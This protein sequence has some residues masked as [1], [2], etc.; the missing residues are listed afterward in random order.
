MDFSPLLETCSSTE[1]FKFQRIEQ[2]AAFLREADLYPDYTRIVS[3]G[4]EPEV[5]IDGRDVLMFCSNNYLSLSNS[6]EVKDAASEA[7]LA[8]GMGPG[9]S[10]CLCGNVAVLDDLDKT[11]AELVSMPAAITFPTGYMANLA[12]FRGL[13]DPF[14]G[15]FP[16][17]K[18]SA[19]VFCDEYNHATIMDGIALSHAKRVLFAHNDLRQLE[20]KLVKFAEFTP[21]L[22]VTEGVFSLDGEVS[23]LAELVELARKHDAI[24]MVDDAHGIGM[25]GHRGGGTLDHLGLQGKAD[26]VMGSFDKALGGMGGFIGSSESVVDYLRVSA[27]P[28]MFSSAVPEVMAAGMIR[29]IQLCMNDSGRRTRLRENAAYLRSGLQALG[30]TILGDGSVPVVPIHIGDEDAAIAFARRTLELGL[31][32]PPFRWPTVPMKTAR[33]RVSPMAD[34]TREHLDRAIGI[35]EQVGRELD[36]LGHGA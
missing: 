17:R 1:D 23:P 28:Y 13:L 9:G 22:I 4:T 35:F 30:F 2:V 20:A 18:G 7:L 14:L 27:R 5:V 21:K 33:I 12:V 8:H 10:R 19:A 3:A 6:R 25:M 29:S 15:I 16:Y 11:C 31:Y 34:H 36:M 32:A 26:I 24:L